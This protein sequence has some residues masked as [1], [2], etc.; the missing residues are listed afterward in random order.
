M[1]EVYAQCVKILREIC[2]HR[3]KVIVFFAISKKFL[4]APAML[5]IFSEM[6]LTASAVQ[7]E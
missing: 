4:L 5:I 3:V 1:R 6:V 2:I 7:S